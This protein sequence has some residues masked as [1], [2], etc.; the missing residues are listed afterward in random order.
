MIGAF[1]TRYRL[2]VHGAP[3]ILDTGRADFARTKGRPRVKAISTFL[4]SVLFL[5]ICI[6]SWTIFPL[7]FVVGALA[8][9][10]YALA[11]ESLHSLIGKKPA[12]PDE[13]AV[14]KIA[15]RMVQTAAHPPTA[16]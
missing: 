13:R 2:V 7:L 14:R 5:G 4:K 11:A 12:Q 3:I 6:V 9:F 16:P 10:F 1:A 15:D 8:L